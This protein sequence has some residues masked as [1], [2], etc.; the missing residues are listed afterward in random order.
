MPKKSSSTATPTEC[1]Y[2]ASRA[3]MVATLA[4]CNPSTS[5]S[6]FK[7]CTALQKSLDK[8]I[9]LYANAGFK[10]TEALSSSRLAL[11]GAFS[12]HARQQASEGHYDELPDLIDLVLLAATSDVCDTKTPFVMLEDLLE[13]TTLDE[14][15]KLFDFIEKRRDVICHTKFIPGDITKNTKS[16]LA[17]LRISNNLLRRLSHNNDTEFCGRIVMFLA[18]AYPLNERSGVNLKGEVN[19]ANTTEY[20]EEVDFVVDEDEDGSS[21]NSS[22]SNNNSSNSSNNSSNS[23]NNSSNSSSNPAAE[24][25]E[26][27]IDYNLYRRF[28]D[29][30]KY[31]SRPNMAYVD[32]NHW[33][34]FR[35]NVDTMLDAFEG[36]A[37]SSDLSTG[38]HRT[39]GQTISRKRIS[40]D[41]GESSSTSSSS[42]SSSTSEYNPKFLTNSRLLRLQLRD[43]ELRRTFLCQVLILCDRL[44]SGQVNVPTAFKSMR[45]ADYLQTVRDRSIALLRATPTDGAAFV[46]GVLHVLDRERDLWTQWKVDKCPSYERYEHEGAEEEDKAGRLKVVTA[47]VKTRRSLSKGDKES[48]QGRRQAAN[49]TVKDSTSLLWDTKHLMSNKDRLRAAAE[50]QRT[51]AGALNEFRE[52]VDEADDPENGIEEEYHPKNEADFAWKAMRSLSQSHLDLFEF[53]EKQNGESAGSIKTAFQ[54]LRDKEKGVE[55]KNNKTV[56]KIA[57]KGKIKA[58]I[59]AATKIVTEQEDST[60]SKRGKRKRGEEEEESDDKKEEEIVAVLKKSKKSVLKKK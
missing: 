34:E 40:S 38:D 9:A 53:I 42:P 43:P 56:I 46:R 20:E 18:Y 4:S 17:L 23:S 50:R 32:L 22:S 26:A 8:S 27:T 44:T 45:S 24:E 33:K 13:A 35:A 10:E 49:A 60:A 52:R 7:I 47:I 28:W 21:S 31:A 48:T 16:K 11:E 54:K 3:D 29:V 51:V 12:V 36:H 15:K 5:S 19:T 41:G 1:I 59:K 39:A 6:R 58:V 25:G 2:D 55:L 37:L 30:Q 57:S 14:C